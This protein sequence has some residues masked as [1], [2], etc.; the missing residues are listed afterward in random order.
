M[1]KQI[2]FK[3]KLRL[4]GIDIN[5]IKPFPDNGAKNLMCIFASVRIVQGIK[6]TKV[7]ISNPQGMAL[8]S[9]EID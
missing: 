2:N 4:C 6:C 9:T 8:L 1:I 5:K 7:Q 3:L